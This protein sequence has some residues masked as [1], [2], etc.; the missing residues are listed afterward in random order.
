[1]SVEE[2]IR[3]LKAR[4]T[5]AQARVARATVE[6]ENASAALERSR[7]ALWT[8]FAVRNP[9]EA[10]AKLA[11]LEATLAAELEAVRAALADA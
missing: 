6:R 2:Q 4:I 1:M 7:A 10:K 8:E 3:D 11:E 9:D 5:Q